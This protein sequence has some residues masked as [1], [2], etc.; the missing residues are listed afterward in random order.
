MMTTFRLPYLI[1]CLSCSQRK[2]LFCSNLITSK[3]CCN[4][5][6]GP[7]KDLRLKHPYNGHFLILTKRKFPTPL[8]CFLE[9]FQ[10]A[11]K[12]KKSSAKKNLKVPKTTLWVFHF[13]NRKILKSLNMVLMFSCFACMKLVVIDLIRV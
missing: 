8:H 7:L 1:I 4:S 2:I 13:E 6:A 11:I 10:P 9:L 5:V 12:N 3:G